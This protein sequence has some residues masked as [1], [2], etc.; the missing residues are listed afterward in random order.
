[1][2]SQ[3]LPYCLPQIG[4]AEIEEV[5]DSIRSGWVTTG[6]KV[7]RFEENFA[8]YVGAGQAIAV[9]SC[10][11]ALQIAMSGMGIGPGDEVLTPTMT[12]CATANVVTHLGARPVLV[13]ADQDGL[14]HLPSAEAA[15]TGRTKAIV[16]VHYA[17]QACDMDKITALARRRGLLV[18][19]DAAHAVGATYRQ[20]RVGVHGDAVAFS[21]YATK[22][23]TT[24]EGGMITTKDENLAPLLRRLAL[25]GMNRD[26]WKRYSETGSWF[27]EVLEPGFKSNMTDIQAAIG[28]HQLRRLESFIDRRRAIAA[29][30]DSAFGSLDLIE[31]PR[32]L[33]DRRHVYHLYAV[34][35]REDLLAIDRNAFID[36]LKQAGIGASVHFIPLHRHPYYRDT[37]GYRPQQFPLAERF[38]SGLVSLPL[39]PRMS[40]A[41][42]E[43]VATAVRHI[44]IAHR[45]RFHPAAARMAA[46]AEQSIKPGG[47]DEQRA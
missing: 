16:P 7:K 33:P 35:L 4:E 38:Y 1:M 8:R 26:A 27:Y 19:E 36:L 20:Q 23:M 18:I 41:D 37:F 5:V 14:I 3:F 22:N 10:T 39:Y 45:R 29:R 31:L 11:A 24:G 47:M 15:I 30:Y 12:F 21:F 43:D 42:V 28:L 17:G 40:D 13:D 9:S 25:H 32:E 44:L 6:P 2:R 46:R 34:R